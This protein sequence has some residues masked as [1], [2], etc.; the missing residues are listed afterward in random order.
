[1]GGQMNSFKRKM[2]EKI[3]TYSNKKYLEGYIKD[4]YLTVDG[5]ADLYLTLNSIDELIDPR[6]S[7]NQLDVCNEIYEFIETKSDMLDNDV[8]L[9]LHI[10][11]IDIDSKTQ[12]TVKH[13]IKEHYAIELYKIQKHFTRCRNKII[14][15][16][17]LGIISLIIYTLIYLNTESDFALEIFGFIFTFAL[18]E[19]F[20]N[21]IYD[22]SD[23]K[24]ERENVTQ[25][26]LMKVCFDEQE[27]SSSDEVV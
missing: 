14:G 23:I 9:E 12:G 4:E 18:W 25:N 20:D 21:L 1:M 26:L 27:K 3:K 17:I 19:A 10:R 22:L 6:T 2:Y 7:D 15:L 16:S 24:Y 13:I 5:D 11:G 8:L